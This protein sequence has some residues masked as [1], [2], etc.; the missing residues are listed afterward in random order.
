VILRRRLLAILIAAVLLRLIFSLG[1][2]RGALHVLP[3]REITDGY[4][5]IAENLD[6]GLGYRELAQLPPTVSRPP[7]Y[8]IFLLG[9]FKLFGV[10]Y[11][12]VQVAQAMMGALGCW[13]L[14]EMGR[15]VLSER[16]G[17]AAAALFAV[18]PNAVEYSARL[19]AENLYFP[20][21]L[22]LAYLLCRASME[23]S[24]RRGLAAGAIW[25]VGI[26]TRGTLV[27]LPLALPFG[28]ALSP[29]H[30]RPRAR[31]VRWT[32]P[33]AVAAVIV[34]A[35]WTI[36]N[37]RLTGRFV[38]VSAWGWAPFYHGLQCSKQMLRWADLRS[39]DKEADQRRY[40]IVVERLYGGDRTKAFA[41]SREY[42][43]HEDVA[44]DLVLEEIRRDPVG[45]FARGLAGIPFAWFLTLGPKMRV[46]SLIIHLPLMVLF[47]VGTV[48]MRR[49]HPEAFTRA[50]PALGLIVFVNVFQ[51]FLF[52]H[53][54]YMSPAIALSFLFAALPLTN[55]IEGGR[56]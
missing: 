1:V 37:E 23:G 53:V 52:P 41:S 55:F 15:W 48:R 10:R 17:L 39:V 14:F 8:P 18:Y 56:A 54:R 50:L 33:A 21:F 28:I 2:T 22:G 35:P 46:V 6:R 40:Q 51:A 27:A 24:V 47:G 20:L 19:Y 5:Q 31:W 4:N 3:E 43:R 7:G 26:L 30:R 16:L 44:R 49:R 36:R 11:L 12:W 38:P 13:I 45:T 32:V 9:L 29:A 25:G 42:V 34:V